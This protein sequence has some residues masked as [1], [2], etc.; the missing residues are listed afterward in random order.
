MEKFSAKTAY[1]SYNIQFFLN[2][3]ADTPL[4]SNSEAKVNNTWP[5]L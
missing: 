2:F 3:I 5:K 4:F 1:A